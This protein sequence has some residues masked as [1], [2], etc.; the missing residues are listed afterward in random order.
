MTN[1]PRSQ[2]N[3]DFLD[4][5]Y[6]DGAN[7]LYLEQMQAKYIANPNSVDPS[8]RDYF[9]AL[10]EDA[11][12]VQKTAD[13]P[14]WGRSDWPQDP[15]D[16]LTSALTGEWSEA[17]LSSKIKAAKPSASSSD[18]EQATK[19]S[20]R[21]LMLIRAYR[22]RGHLIADLDPLELVKRELHPELDPATYGFSKDDYDRQIF[23]DNVLG[24]KTATLNVILEML[25]PYLL[26]DLWRAVH[27][28]F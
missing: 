6:L 27:A 3:Q 12:S 15:S 18:I 23:L 28:R 20:V 21:A 14:A 17:K 7:A 25:Q 2:Q 24:L 8:W 5:L 11:A 9:A 26:F 13:G 19:D 1:K 4:T 16:E 22:I 10:G